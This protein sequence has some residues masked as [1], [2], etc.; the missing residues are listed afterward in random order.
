MIFHVVL[1]VLQDAKEGVRL[2][3]QVDVVEVVLAIAAENVM[4]HVVDL[5]DLDALVVA[6]VA[7]CFL[8]I[9]N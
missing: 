6:L 7:L 8:F 1:V 2:L 9:V 5:V 3:V 4:V